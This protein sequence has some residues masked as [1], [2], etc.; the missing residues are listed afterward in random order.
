MT[1]PFEKRL[2]P[3]VAIVGP[4]GSG[5]TALAIAIAERFDGEIV[6]CDSLQIYRYLDIGTAKPTPE[7]RAKVPHHLIDILD[8]DDVFTAGD[9]V[10]LARAV[11]WD[12]AGRGGLPVITGGTGFYLRALIHGLFT[13]PGKNEALRQRLA[14]KPRRLH[15]L[16]EKLDAAAADRIHPNDTKKLIRALE[17]C[18]LARRPITDV[19]HEEGREPLHGFRCLTIGLDPPREELS[20]CLNRRTAQMFEAGLIPEAERVT[21]MGYTPEAKA[22]EAIGYREAFAHLAGK[23]TYAEAVEQAQIATRQY[24]KRQRTWFRKEPDVI[25]IRDFGN[26]IETMEVAIRLVQELKKNL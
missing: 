11:L 26:R 22:F 24:A 8:P 5:K 12:I 4:T 21:R 9:Y 16:L 17:V 6:N 18:I 7:E 25:W 15:R 23:L 1:S 20:A 19:Q 14:Q 10:R 13:G 3:A 2:H